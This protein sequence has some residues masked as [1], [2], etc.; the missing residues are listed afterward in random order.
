MQIDMQTIYYIVAAAVLVIGAVAGLVARLA[1]SEKVKRKAQEV[2]DVAAEHLRLLAV[3]KE[4][5]INTEDKKN[6]TAVEKHEYCKAMIIDKC[7][8]EAID[9]TQFD[10]DEEIANNMEIADNINSTHKVQKVEE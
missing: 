2:A 4:C 7:I 10:L 5:M 9:Y 6:F 8:N 3:V 1:K